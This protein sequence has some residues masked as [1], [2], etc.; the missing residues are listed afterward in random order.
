MSLDVKRVWEVCKPRDDVLHG[1]LELQEF[2]VEFSHVL[3]G[4]A[5]RVYQDAVEFFKRTYPTRALKNLL[6]NVLRR[7]AGVGGTPIFV[8][9]TGFGGGK[10]HTLLAVYHL[11]KD[12]NRVH[13]LDFVQEVLREAGLR[14]IPD[15]TVVA[16]DGKNLDP[17]K[18][19]R[20]I[21]GEIARQLGKYDIARDKDESFVVLTEGEVRKILG[22]DRPVI[23]LIDEVG[24]YFSMIYGA[25]Q[26]RYNALFEQIKEFFRVLASVVSSAESRHVLIVTIPAEAPYDVPIVRLFSDIREVLGRQGIT[27]IPIEQDEI[28]H[29]IRRRLFEHVDE[30]AAEKIVRKFYEYYQKF[31]THFPSK[32]RKPEYLDKLRKAYPFHPELIDI[33]FERV[34][35]IPKF[36]KT[37]GVLRLLALIVRDVWSTKPDDAYVIMPKHV[38]LS[39]SEILNELTSRLGREDYYPV[40]TS[41]IE[42]PTGTGK[43]Q[44]H[45]DPLYL[46]VSRAIYLYSLIGTE[47]PLDE[48][49]PTIMDI[50]LAVATPEL[51]DPSRVEQVLKDLSYELWYLH[52]VGD[53]YCFRTEPNINKVI[54]EEKGNISDYTARER[55][56]TEL[57]VKLKRQ[58]E[59]VLRGFRCI[60]WDEPEDSP[61]LKIVILDPAKYSF[62][63]TGSIPELP[64]SLR[65]L[66]EKLRYKNTVVFLLPRADKFYQ[67]LDWARTV[68]ACE[69]LLRKREFEKHRRAIEE[70]KAYALAN[71]ISSIVYTYQFVAYPTRIG[72][73]VESLRLPVHIPGKEEDY[74]L[75]AKSLKETLE[76]APAFKLTPI[77][78]DYLWDMYFEEGKLLE[79]Y[80][81]RIE[82][83]QVLEDL[84]ICPAYPFVINE[85]TVLQAL[86]EL[87][88]QGKLAYSGSRGIV[89][90][91]EEVWPDVCKIL[92]EAKVLAQ[93][94]SDLAKLLDEFLSR[95]HREGP[96]ELTGQLLTMEEAKKL[97]DDYVERLKALVEQARERLKT[98]SGPREVSTVTLTTQPQPRKIEKI[99]K[100]PPEDLREG[101]LEEITVNASKPIDAVNFLTQVLT[102]LRAKV[103]IEIYIDVKISVGGFTLVVSGM[104]DNWDNVR[105]F[106]MDLHSFYD[107]LRK[108]YDKVEC[109][110]T[111]TVT[112]LEAELKG[113]IVK[114]LTDWLNSYRE[115]IRYVIRIRTLVQ[116]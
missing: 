110:C 82:V 14:N 92:S 42:S 6:V 83:K 17:T 73:K 37:R 93:H 99:I 72:L 48:V 32:V 74:F 75:L 9:V 112:K 87:V 105:A 86:T 53:R 44:L 18:R 30:S 65:D 66:Y 4:V 88:K 115:D 24:T 28:Y 59:A 103:G 102:L 67:A 89:V 68:R 47:R 94:D 71:M 29:V 63:Y 7:V 100:V 81:G 13:D 84:K 116:D 19:P 113:N 51:L 3:T 39:N 55:I 54:A 78:A 31:E 43:A 16:I 108:R 56:R 107:S 95:F 27:S 111:V 41:D 21:W 106:L 77:P 25:E 45:R 20:T 98:R 36:Q 60:V 70:H 69:S 109:T 10:T 62:I 2:G 79:R 57:E 91:Y 40:I 8:L 34:S 46:A 23:I 85:S 64:Q 22:F 49:A 5:P 90:N 61:D 52:K 15:A 38:N 96:V 12:R 104:R 33:L 58:I 11:F 35:T 80:G 50:T 1:K 26:N 97:I 76:G 101:K 114:L